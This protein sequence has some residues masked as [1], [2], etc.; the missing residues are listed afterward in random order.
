MCSDLARSKEAWKRGSSSEASVTAGKISWRKP[1]VWDVKKSSTL[2][3]IEKNRLRFQCCLIVSSLEFLDETFCPFF[4]LSFL[5]WFQFRIVVTK[6]VIYYVLFQCY[7]TRGPAIL[8]NMSQVM[9]D[10][11]TNS[12][13]FVLRSFDLL[14]IYLF[15]LSVCGIDL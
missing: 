11:H 5:V 12:T 14:V 2:Q 4:S 10:N 8:L 3:I 7:Y 13:F 1:K 15:P 9:T 6:C